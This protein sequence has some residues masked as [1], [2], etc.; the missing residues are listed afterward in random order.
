MFRNI[1]K[2]VNDW[3]LSRRVEQTRSICVT[4]TGGLGAQI[5]SYGIYENFIK[6]GYTVA[7]DLTYFD[8]APSI[9]PLNKGEVSI[10]EWELDSYGVKRE[11]LTPPPPIKDSSMP[12]VHDSRLK[13]LLALQAMASLSV[14]DCFNLEL[15]DTYSYNYRHNELKGE[16][17]LCVHVR[18]G[19]YIN[20]AS[21]LINNSELEGVALQLAGFVDRVLILSDSHIAE[22]QFVSLRE[23]F[24]G[25]IHTID[26][27]SD[28]IFAHSL[29]RN[30]SA[31]VC[32]NSQF[33]LSAG[34]LSRGLVVIPNAWFG[35][36]LNNL[37]QVIN[38]K[39]SN[40]SVLQ[41]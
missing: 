19:D 25:R 21:H 22:D 27:E 11:Y 41:K 26:D 28:P 32:C 36:N 39:L 14:R 34:L 40:F 31:L 20:V 2:C 37:N 4:F 17:Y 13:L 23:A 30:A 35:K 16:R 12:K 29:M 24:R 15:N 10:W 33:S 18:R 9:A 6:Q 7:A 3:R 1:L 5:L 8:K 38:N